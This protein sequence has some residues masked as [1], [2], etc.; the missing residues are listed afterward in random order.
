MKKYINKNAYRLYRIFDKIVAG[1]VLTGAEAK[2]IRTRGIE[3]RDS[4]ARIKNGEIFLV[5][6]VIHPY[7]FA[8]VE[9]QIPTRERKLL[10]KESEIKKLTETKKRKLTI[11]PVSCYNK[12]RWVK[13]ELGI[14]K[15]KSKRERKKDL[16]AK[17]LE[18]EMKTF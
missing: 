7:P 8:R 16:M 4:L 11:V 6:A 15:I 18:R 3:L 9:D 13:I 17:D 1:I 12:G 10:L 14:G 2:S 5:N